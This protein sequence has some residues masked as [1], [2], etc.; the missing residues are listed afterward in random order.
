MSI[1]LGWIYLVI[2]IVITYLSN[3]KKIWWILKCSNLK[4]G[5]DLKKFRN[6]VDYD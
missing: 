4:D 1:K 5:V 6:K 2:Y 3:I